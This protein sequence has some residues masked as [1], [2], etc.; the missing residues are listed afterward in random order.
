[1]HNAKKAIL[2][3]FLIMA[4]SMVQA[5]DYT[6]VNHTIDVQISTEGNDTTVEKFFLDFPTD[7][8]KIAFRN[9]SLSLG[10]N[11]EQWTSLDPLF[12]PSLGQNTLNKKISYTEGTQN[13]LQ[14]S[15]DLSEPLMAKGKET[16][17]VT[18]YLL[19]VNYFNSF[20]QSG[21][22]IIP[23]KTTINIELP[24]GAEIR[25]TIEPGAAITTSG[26]RK[27]V[28]WNGY[29]SGNRLTLNYILWKKIDPVIDLNGL[30]AFL[31]KTNIGLVLVAAII[32]L[33]AVLIWKRHAI[34]EKIEEFAENNS[35][36]QEE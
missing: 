1:M 33:L 35:I 27:T 26:S 2:F 16:T 28:S 30:T 19:K 14:I 4:L 32:I 22:W 34:K 9:T 10:T 21:L 6:I 29:K 7:T 31:F 13:Y 3:V 24:P 25:D 18:E 20:Y 8:A 12:A 23:D 5:L 17:M 11:L 36:I 15:Y